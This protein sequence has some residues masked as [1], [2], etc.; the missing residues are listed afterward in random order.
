MNTKLFFPLAILFFVACTETKVDLKTEE[1]AI[2]KLIP[3]GQA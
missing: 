3:H 1:A 2:L